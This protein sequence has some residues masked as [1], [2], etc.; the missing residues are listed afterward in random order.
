VTIHSGTCRQVFSDES[1]HNYLGNI[2]VAGKTGTLRP[3]GKD[4]TT[5]WF[6][7]FA[8]SRKPE[9]CVAVMLQNPPVWRRKASE[10]ARDVLRCHF[11]GRAGVKNPFEIPR[12]PTS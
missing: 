2:S 5:S 4:A 10:V 6:L 7:G 1:G 3:D 8:P 9:I 12:A 11:A